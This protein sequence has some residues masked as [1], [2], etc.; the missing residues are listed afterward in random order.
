MKKK[1]FIGLSDI[2]SF[3]D[4]WDFGFKAN[5]FKSLKGS[6]HYQPSVQ[7]SKL[8][9]VI[10][11]QQD[12]V[13]FFKPRRISSK[14]KP[15]WD[16][17]VSD[18]YLH[19]AI[20]ECDIFIFFW[21][22]F[23]A[24]FSDYKLLKQKGKKIITVFVGDD[25][26]W[27]SAMKQEFLKYDLPIIEYEN[28]N[29]SIK[30]L[31][32]KLRF[33]RTAEKYSDII[34][35]QPNLMQLALKPYF[36]LHI[37]IISKNYIEKH[38]QRLKPVI[39]HAPTSVGKGTKHIE[40]VIERLKNEGL[41]FE[42]QRIQNV[43]RAKALEIYNNADII[44]DQV[45]TPGGGKLAYE[46]LAMGK[47][48]LTLMAYNAYD[49]QK[50]SECPLVDVRAENLYDT[51]KQLIPDVNLRTQIA[52]KGRS[53]I[54]KYHNPIE[55]VRKLLRDLENKQ[56]SQP[57]YYPTFYRNEFIPENFEMLQEYNKWNQYVSGC[58]WYKTTVK[59]ANRAG[60]I[61]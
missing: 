5:H 47:I 55:I 8:D 38:E 31:G 28:Y 51:L 22:S 53:Y 35:G 26:R 25:V 24:D 43:P 11:K 6:I 41:D 3:I 29:R 15:W 9:F 40:P 19:K 59:P 32:N 2:A 20:N 56:L 4:D 37:P 50:P 58:D 7:N 34:L 42:Y 18:Y 39:V 52:L 48:V 45:L 44:L 60:L 61:F 17:R 49:Q 33:L 14:F 27:E 46:G 57:D 54:E 30:G 1:V 12:K 21:E 13:G 36:N 16:A 23:N 10:K